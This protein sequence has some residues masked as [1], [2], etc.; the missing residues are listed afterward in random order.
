MVNSDTATAS[1]PT[2]EV[3][4][5]G[6]LDVW[7]APG[8]NTTLD[9]AIALTPKQLI[10]DLEGCPSIDA[11]GILLLLDAHRRAIRN[12]GVVALRSPSARLMRNLRL[13]RVD[14]VLQVLTPCPPDAHRQEDKP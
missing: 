2:V 3:V 14:R 8:I 12:G 4:V 5:R 9:E 1:I 11:A 6:D 13:A 10:I 7:T